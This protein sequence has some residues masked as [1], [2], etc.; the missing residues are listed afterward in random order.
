MTDDGTNIE[1]EDDTDGLVVFVV[2]SAAEVGLKKLDPLD[3]VVAAAFV[4][5]VAEG[6]GG[7]SCVGIGGSLRLLLINGT[8]C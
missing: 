2:V 8:T 5:I 1:D 3:V 7:G 4:A 6:R